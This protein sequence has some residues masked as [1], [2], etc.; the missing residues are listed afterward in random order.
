MCKICLPQESLFFYLMGPGLL[1]YNDNRSS[2]RH[3]HL[4]TKWEIPTYSDDQKDVQLLRN[5]DKHNTAL[6]VG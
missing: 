2:D 5:F 3:D 1:S 4:Y 6:S